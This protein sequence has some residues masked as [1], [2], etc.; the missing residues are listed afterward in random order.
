MKVGILSSVKN[1]LFNNIT[2]KQTI[3]KNTFWLSAYSIT[4]RL[5]KFIFLIYVA[6][7]LGA[8]DYGKFTF[9]LAF[10]SLF[11]VFHDFGL[12]TIVIREFAKD[13]RDDRE[14]HSVV[15]LKV[16]LSLAAFLLMF[17]SSFF[18][19]QE[20]DV[21][22]VIWILAVFSLVNGLTTIFYTFSQARQ[23]MEHQAYAA[24]FQAILTVGFG[25]FVLFKIPSVENLSY[26]YLLA[27]LITLIG[28]LFFFH[29]KVLRLKIIW[30]KSVLKKFIA[31]SWPLALAGLFGML[32]SYIDSVMMGYWGMMS[33]A[34]WYNAAYRV[35][36]VV[37][38]PIGFI[39]GSFYPVLSSFFEAGKENL[40]NIWNKESKIM[41]LLA[42]PLA[43]G[44][45]VLA[46]KLIGAIYPEFPPSVLVF[47]I[48]AIMAGIIFF[49]RPLYDIM[50]VANLQK[51][52]FWITLCGALANIILNIILIPRYSLY[53]AA[54][55]TVATYTVIFLIS[56]FLTVRFTPIR[57][58]NKEVISVLVAAVV[59]GSLMSFFIKWS[60][61][62]NLNVFL[63][64]FAGALFYIFLLFLLKKISNIFNLRMI[65]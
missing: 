51:K 30:E 36:Y 27:A 10:T 24:V 4:D 20:P 15:S 58:I 47:Q 7:I 53:G 52:T 48:L 18:I 43:L 41:I 11:V 55:A 9:A 22:K 37:L 50:I 40:Q 42:L 12:S 25:F 17:L 32:Y 16:V 44:G 62:Y 54:W 28:V 39:S 34:G 45:I 61:I 1:L 5:I 14:F 63:S 26:S 6:R 38:M 33:E 49:Y 35:I 8:P 3:F 23:K 65:R 56:F 13:K 46:P 2:V 19:T 29:F 59:S 31:M 60:P 64:I 57:P 21:R